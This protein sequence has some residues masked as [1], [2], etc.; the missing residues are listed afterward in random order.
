MKHSRDGKHWVQVPSQ[1]YIKQDGTKSYVP[2][3]EFS[4]ADR[5]KQFNAACLAAIDE[6]SGGAE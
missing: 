4:S 5:W 1:Q 2:I 6:L 3:V